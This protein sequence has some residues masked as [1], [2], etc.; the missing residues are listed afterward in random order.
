MPEL[1]ALSVLVVG[2][3]RGIGL[4]TVDRLVAAGARPIVADRDAEALGGVGRRHP[5]VE[6]HRLD[7]TDRA[8][9][10]SFV[11]GLR[12]RGARPAAAVRPP[13]SRARLCAH[14]AR[15]HGL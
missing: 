9:V 10:L 2:G 6:T 12:D 4:E 15:R 3:A 5:Q 7:I 13:L 8:G 11:D 14:R 1:K